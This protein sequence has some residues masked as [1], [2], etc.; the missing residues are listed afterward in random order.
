MAEDLT[1]E[2][3]LIAWRRL[4]DLP[5]PP[6]PWLLGVTRNLLRKQRARRLRTEELV[7]RLAQL[8]TFVEGDVAEKV[9]NRQHA[10]AALTGLK[11]QD[12]EVLIL[13]SWCGM[14]SAEAAEVAGCSARTYEVR[15]HRARQRL[16]KALQST[17][18]FT[19]QEQT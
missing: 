15:L 5:D 4:D 11:G 17:P 18:P 1:S 13:T 2:T 19:L 9:A 14:T 7:A 6:L 12:V 16:R 3:F 10:L 8:T